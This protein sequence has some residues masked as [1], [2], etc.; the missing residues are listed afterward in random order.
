MVLVKWPTIIDFSI[1]CVFLLEFVNGSLFQ[2]DF[3]KLILTKNELVSIWFIFGN[4]Y[5]KSDYNRMNIV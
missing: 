2:F 5:I 4:F 1:K 3:T